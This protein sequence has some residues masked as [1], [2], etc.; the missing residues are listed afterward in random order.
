MAGMAAPNKTCWT[1]S[2][3]SRRRIRTCKTSWTQLPI[4]FRR[5]KKKRKTKR[6]MRIDEPGVLNRKDA[7]QYSRNCRTLKAI[8]RYEE[9]FESA[10]DSNLNSLS[11]IAVLDASGIDRTTKQFTAEEFGKVLRSSNFV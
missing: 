11:N 3:I 6:T 4:S 7:N 10:E 1:K 2:R 8:D 5:P 9:F